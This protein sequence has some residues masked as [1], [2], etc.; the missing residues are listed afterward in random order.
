MQRFSTG[1]PMSPDIA[2][3]NGRP[4]ENRWATLLML[5]VATLVLLW[6]AAINRQPFLFA[7]TT[8]YVRGADAAL[9]KATGRASP[10]TQELFRRF[11][12]PVA[13]SSS[14]AKAVLRTGDVS[15]PQSRAVLSGRSIYYGLFLYLLTAGSF[16]P[17]AIVQALLT[18]LCLLVTWRTIASTAGWPPALFL[19]LVAG[20]SVATPLAYF[21]CYAMP[22]LFAGLGI[23]ASAMLLAIPSGRRRNAMFWC[24]VLV[25]AVA[26]HSG[27]LLLIGGLLV[28]AFA[29]AAIRLIHL[30]RL[31]C[32]AV[33]LALLGGMIG[34]VAFNM[35][36]ARTTGAPPVRPPFIM[37][38]MIDD[39]PG[40]R[41]LREICPRTP[42]AY[43]VCRY[44][45]RLPLNSDAFLWDSSAPGGVFMT[46]PVAEQRALSREQVRFALD[47]IA[48]RPMEQ[49][50]ATLRNMLYQARMIGLPE[51]RYDRGMD[52][53]LTTKLP[54]RYLGQ[55]RN[56]LAFHGRM[57][58]DPTAMLTLLSTLG[59][60]VVIG[61]AAA[62]GCRS[63]RNWSTPCAAALLVLAG[64]LAN[65]IIC[66]GMSTPHDR[67]QARVIWL[68]P[69]AAM[70]AWS[71]I[72]RCELLPVSWTPR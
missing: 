70:F 21:V 52:A 7:D 59:S 30:Q 33:C 18:A 39:G 22:D 15:G 10:W 4:A 36:V 50:T 2:T 35:A 5:F 61:L 38:R 37:A 49:A 16:W 54:P 6:P 56:T 11:E 27:T 46:V 12:A 28:A 13:Q 53:F 60:L 26:F 63:W 51:F 34:E 17:V 8:A 62:R 40:T 68:L 66:G 45:D 32:V 57:P 25:A 3:E 67:Y 1:S 55:H 24:A 14:A 64:L 72:R 48:H 23:L 65:V 71:A 47:V 42:D 69:I 20:L 43:V 44:L 58:V 19:P 41:H 29:L 31:G 9:F